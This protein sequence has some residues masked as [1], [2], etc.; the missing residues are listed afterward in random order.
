MGYPKSICTSINEVICHGIPCDRK[1]KNGDIM[2]IDVTVILDGWYGDTSRMYAIGNISKRAQELIDTTYQCMMD[3]ID[4]L[5]PGIHLGDIGDVIRKICKKHH[6]SIVRDYCG[7]GVGRSFHE[8]PMVLHSAKGGTGP[9]LKPGY[10]F[11]V[12]PMINEGYYA[13]RVL[14]DE[15]TAVTA[16]GSLSAQYEHTIGITEDGYEI[17]TK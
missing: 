2:N 1:L 6:F 3:A 9:I 5:K 15:W 16:D 11:T 4:I 8:D 17:F 10:I 7:H 13:S 12:E 14:D